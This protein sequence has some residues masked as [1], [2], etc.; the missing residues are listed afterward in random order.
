MSTYATR[1]D[2]DVQQGLVHAQHWRLNDISEFYPGVL[3]GLVD[4]FFG[5]GAQQ[6][7][8]LP[9]PAVYDDDGTTGRILHVSGLCPPGYENYGSVYCCPDP[10]NNVCTAGWWNYDCT[11]SSGDRRTDTPTG[12]PTGTPTTAAPSY[13]PTPN[14]PR[15]CQWRSQQRACVC[16]ADYWPRSSNGTDNICCSMADV[17]PSREYTKDCDCAPTPPPTSVPTSGPT[18][19]LSYEFRYEGG[20]WQR[21][22]QLVLQAYDVYDFTFEA[23]G[24]IKTELFDLR[25][26]GGYGVEGNTYLVDNIVVD[27]EQFKDTGNSPPSTLIV[28]YKVG[29]YRVHGLSTTMATCFRRDLTPCNSVAVP[30]TYAFSNQPFGVVWS[31]HGVSAPATQTPAVGSTAPTSTPT[32]LAFI[33]RVNSTDAPATARGVYVD[34]GRWQAISQREI[35][36]WG[37]AGDGDGRVPLC[38]GGEA[39]TDCGE[40]GVVACAADAPYMCD[41]SPHT[42][43]DAADGCNALGGLRPC[44][45]VGFDM[46]GFPA[47]TPLTGTTTL[48]TKVKLNAIGTP[49][50]GAPAATCP[51][52]H[53]IAMANAPCEHGFSCQDTTGAAACPDQSIGWH[54]DLVMNKG[55]AT[56]T[57]GPVAC[58]AACEANPDCIAAQSSTEG[59]NVCK[60]LSGCAGLVH[61]AGVAV[62]GV[63]P[64]AP[65]RVLTGHDRDSCVTACSQTYGC[66]RW[67]I[68]QSTF[69]VGGCRLS[70]L[71]EDN[72]RGETLR[73]PSY[74]A[75]TSALTATPVDGEWLSGDMPPTIVDR[76]PPET[77]CVGLA[78][79]TL[80]PGARV[81]TT[82]RDSSPVRLALLPASMACPSDLG[83]YSLHKSNCK[84]LPILCGDVTEICK[85]ALSRLLG[86]PAV[87]IA[88]VSRGDLARGCFVEAG[89]WF[90]NTNFEQH[91]CLVATSGEQ[92]PRMQL[93]E[94]KHPM[95]ASMPASEYGCRV[96]T[97]LSDLPCDGVR[98]LPLT[99][100]TCLLHN[101]I[102]AKVGSAAAWETATCNTTVSPTSHKCTSGLD[103]G[104]AARICEVAFEEATNA[105]TNMVSS[106]DHG[107]CFLNATGALHL[108]GPAPLRD[109]GARRLLQVETIAIGIGPTYDALVA[110]L[111]ESGRFYSNDQLRQLYDEAM[112]RTRSAKAPLWLALSFKPLLELLKTFDESD[113]VNREIERTMTLPQVSALLQ[114]GGQNAWITL[115]QRQELLDLAPAMYATFGEV[116]VKLSVWEKEL[117]DGGGGPYMFDTIPDILERVAPGST[118]ELRHRAELAKMQ[119][120]G[121][122][123]ADLLMS[124]LGGWGLWTREPVV[125]PTTAPTTAPTAHAIQENEVTECC[126]AGFMCG[127]PRPETH[128]RLC[129][130]FNDIGAYCTG[131]LDDCPSANARSCS[132]RTDSPCRLDGTHKMTNC[133]TRREPLDISLA[134][135][136][137]GAATNVDPG[138][139]KVRC[140]EPYETKVMEI[141]A[142]SNP[143][144]SEHRFKEKSACRDGTDECGCDGALAN[145]PGDQLSALDTRTCVSEIDGAN[146][147]GFSGVLT[148]TR[149]SILSIACCEQQG[150]Q[151][152]YPSDGI[153]F[154]KT[155]PKPNGEADYVANDLS[156]GNYPGEEEACFPSRAPIT[157]G[158]TKL[159]TNSP[160]KRPSTAPTNPPTTAPTTAPSTA[161]S[162]PL[163]HPPSSAPSNSPTNSPTGSPTYEACPEE[164]RTATLLELS[165]LCA[166]AAAFFEGEFQQGAPQHDPGDTKGNRTQLPT[167]T[168]CYAIPG[169]QG[170]KRTVR[171]IDGNSVVGPTTG[172]S[173]PRHLPRAIAT[174]HIRNT[175]P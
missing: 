89:E 61:T 162:L 110:M 17:C 62:V 42:C 54:D 57:V 167:R 74:K 95:W 151:C 83:W 46:L 84:D 16:P 80:P 52:S 86:M 145:Q 140:W 150:N 139:D 124:K 35:K 85:V 81:H 118:I 3:P 154:C 161:P 116:Q 4:V 157:V 27:E 68:D 22:A 72:Q 34:G 55:S 41:D 163:S 48:V 20:Q 117:F 136:P 66:D 11:C 73:W 60:L 88:T 24:I 49:A 69:G 47:L 91:L 109:L 14:P 2:L 98:L 165:Q 141:C 115:S 70:S 153:G 19:D 40:R 12:T 53:P 128:T 114:Y 120:D 50:A 75:W 33:G 45:A 44:A 104:G 103:M 126:G 94:P 147:L 106:Y 15:V 8:P 36:C 59:V 56:A 63:R 9:P 76:R 92:V 100:D 32:K 58:R 77:A 131:S 10:D 164:S 133:E 121:D 18:M 122:L 97:A 96:R 5:I 129:Y 175:A 90:H 31:S 51:A 79:A 23:Q 99:V 101:N 146:Q 67:A 173:P 71:A 37:R 144:R 152:E 13:A 134:P 78:G 172:A 170:G 21:A 87:A 130:L 169:Y 166:Q 149:R 155:P 102:F 159:P 82:T 119:R 26:M 113:E 105:A 111:P 25:H 65:L 38:G 107:G 132:D 158:P 138:V 43:V 123:T 39:L 112:V 135:P 6:R 125:A 174:P 108:P 29:A 64:Y 143:Y 127:F 30:V 28:R 156:C 1:V 168:G 93:Q 160:T 137:P 142:V 171:W 148:T 7:V